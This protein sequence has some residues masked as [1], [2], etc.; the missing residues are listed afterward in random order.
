[1]VGMAN[2]TI[3]EPHGKDNVVHELALIWKK[4]ERFWSVIKVESIPTTKFPGGGILR[5][6]YH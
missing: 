5:T 3:Y 2:F 6:I 4:E 1:M